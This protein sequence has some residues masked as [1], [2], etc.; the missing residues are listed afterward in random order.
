MDPTVTAEQI[1]EGTAREIMRKIQMARKTADFQMD[2]KIILELA[3]SPSLSE[4]FEAHRA[5]I[6]S[7]TLTG[8][9]KI[10]SLEGTP[11][12]KFSDASDIDGEVIKLG[13]TALP[14][15]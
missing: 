10:L 15:S 13:V 12:G 5:M 8:E 4:A 11:S 14:R 2:D 9:L 3:L 1:R 7:E 6:L